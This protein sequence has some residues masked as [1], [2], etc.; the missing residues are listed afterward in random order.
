MDVSVLIVSFNT[1]ELTLA[2]LKS[3][4]DQTSGLAFE[5]IVVDNASDDGSAGA[6]RSMFPQ[7]RLIVS[8]KNLGFARANNL[9]AKYATGEFILLL[10]PDTVILDGAIQRAVAFAREH[11]E[12]GIV[13]GRTYFGDMSVNRNSCHGRP[14]VWSMFCK[15][16]G[17]SSVFRGSGL[18]DSES[19]GK[20]DRSTARAVDAVTGCFMLIEKGLWD[21]LGGF[22]ESFFMYG[23]DT[24]LCIRAWAVGSGCMI[25]PEARLIHYGGKSE[26]IRADKM[27]R[28]FRAK[29]QLIRRHWSGGT[30][31]FGISMLKWWVG[32]RAAATGI[33]GILSAKAK[34]SGAQWRAVWDRRREFCDVDSEAVS[35]S[36]NPGRV[37]ARVGQ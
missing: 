20:W 6:V 13:G 23:E 14:T 19:L 12:V 37:S 9:A 17:L 30:V 5:L 4:Y 35:G 31:W 3:V 36:A 7:V 11:R 27:V 32:S 1:R 25:C 28:L 33:A 8:D 10:N 24:D 18:V 16:T 15:G 29:A 26:K 2:C 34:T 21:R 22:D